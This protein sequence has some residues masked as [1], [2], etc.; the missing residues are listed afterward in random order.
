MD[1][2]APVEASRRR[3]ELR[4][5]NHRAAV[6][7]IDTD[8]TVITP[9]REVSS[10]RSVS[11]QNRRFVAQRSQRIR[12]PTKRIT[13]TR[14]NRPARDVVSN[15]DATRLVHRSASHPAK[16]VGWREGSLL[17][18]DGI[19]RRKTLARRIAQLIPANPDAR[20]ARHRMVDYHRLVRAEIP[21]T[22]PV[23]QAISQ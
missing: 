19:R 11:Y 9:A 10:L 7:R 16:I 1:P 23:H 8:R 6:N 21:I 13:N 20:S 12:R 14:N 5:E 15:R 17:M 22:Q 18:N 2:R 3:L 4:R